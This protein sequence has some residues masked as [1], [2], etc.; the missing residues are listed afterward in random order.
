[1]RRSAPSQKNRNQDLEER[2]PDR[3]KAAIGKTHALRPWDAAK[4]CAPC[5]AEERTRETG[6]GSTQERNHRESLDLHEMCFR[7]GEVLNEEKTSK[8]GELRKKQQ[9]Q[10]TLSA[11]MRMAAFCCDSQNGS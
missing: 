5:R 7:R 4:E 8:K 10:D 1:M 11:A 6:G 3:Q 2:E 9:M